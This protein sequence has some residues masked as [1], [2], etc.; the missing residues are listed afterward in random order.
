MLLSP[1]VA[2]MTTILSDFSTSILPDSSKSG[3]L[4]TNP[5][6]YKFQQQKLVLELQEKSVCL[7]NK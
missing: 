3:S 7:L 1:F 4:F 6:P 5:F 2:C